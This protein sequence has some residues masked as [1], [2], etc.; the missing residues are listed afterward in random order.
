MKDSEFSQEDHQVWSL[1]FDRQTKLLRSHGCRMFWEGFEH[2]KFPSDHILSVQE[3]NAKITPL[4]GWKTRRTSVRYSSAAQW[5]PL[6]GQRIF[7]VT[8]FVRSLDELD[9]TPEPDVFHDTFGHLAFFTLPR[10]TRFAQI[11]APAFLRAKTQEVQENVK[12]LAWF[13]YEFGVQI[14]D[15]KPKAFGAGLISSSGELQKVISG[16]MKLVPFTIE[17]VLSKDKAIWHMHDTLFT[18]ESLDSLQKKIESYL[19]TV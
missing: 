14:E 13:S 2:I 18:F 11:F 12:R 4:T 9:F 6:F 16:E 8:D 17:N 3:L 1:L 5:Y 19:H 7:P 10:Y 15:G